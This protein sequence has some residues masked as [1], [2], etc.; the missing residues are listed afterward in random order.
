MLIAVLLLAG[1]AAYIAP[2]YLVYAD[3]PVKSDAVILFVG[4]PSNSREKEAARLL[5]EGYGRFLI[6]PAYKEVI[7][8]E[9]FHGSISVWFKSYPGFYERT[10]VEMLYAERIMH[11]LGLRT[12][13]MVSSP[14]HMKRISMIAGRVFGEQSRFF[15][16]VPT[17]YEYD[18]IQLRNMARKNWKF[19]MSEYVKI[20]WFQLY[21]PFFKK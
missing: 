15:S 2:R 19:V 18:P 8:H 21:A 16:Y 13:I 11:A 6:I 1:T 12:A 5:F 17:P 20:C 9:N 4:S 7:S 14:Y 10:H 3:K